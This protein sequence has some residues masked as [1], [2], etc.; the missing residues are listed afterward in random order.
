[1]DQQQ[2]GS[3]K[4]HLHPLDPGS[5]TAMPD[6]QFR[7]TTAPANF[8]SH[9]LL[10]HILAEKALMFTPCSNGSIVWPLSL[11]CYGW[12]GRLGHQG[13]PFVHLMHTE[14][15]PVEQTSSKPPDCGR[16]TPGLF[17]SYKIQALQQ[18][19]NEEVVIGQVRNE[20]GYRL[21]LGSS[22]PHWRVAGAHSSSGQG[23]YLAG[24]PWGCTGV[25]GST[26]GCSSTWRLH[27][28][29]SCRH[30]DPSG[31]AGRS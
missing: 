18:L 11:V 30:R 24:C 12:F 25:L 26:V 27:T 21:T 16:P 19:G 1:M 13:L 29:P 23:L 3:S 6:L 2:C 9:C 5:D 10:C 20:T 8:T 22:I 17:G 7:E 4:L 15:A 31:Q 14:R 28:H